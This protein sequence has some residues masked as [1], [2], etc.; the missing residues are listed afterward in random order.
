[1]EINDEGDKSEEEIWWFNVS[2]NREEIFNSSDFKGAIIGG[3]MCRALAEA[4]MANA[5]AQ[6]PPLTLNPTNK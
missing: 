3:E 2:R 4:I 6:E 1:V 5:A